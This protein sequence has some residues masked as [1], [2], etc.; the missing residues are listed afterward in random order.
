MNKQSKI[1]TGLVL[2]AIVA[3][4]LTPFLMPQEVSA[5]GGI[6][7]MRDTV[8]ITNGI[9]LGDSD[10]MV[11]LDNAGIGATS[12]VE[13]VWRF[14]GDDCALLILETDGSVTTLADDNA[15]DGVDA[16]LNHADSTNAEAVI[17]FG[18][19]GDGCTI[20]QDNAFVTV[21]TILASP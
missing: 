10:A 12:D 15:F 2:G 11:I 14:V 17:L 1:M 13:V 16:S 7:L 9:T 21:S 4:A 20:A 8:N 19:G 6:P 3:I 18:D 5:K